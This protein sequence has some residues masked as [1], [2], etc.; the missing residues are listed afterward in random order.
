M[1]TEQLDGII[2]VY[3]RIYIYTYIYTYYAHIVGY[4]TSIFPVVPVECVVW[5]LSIDNYCIQLMCIYPYVYWPWCLWVWPQYTSGKPAKTN[6]KDIFMVAAPARGRAFVYFLL[7]CL[8]C[9]SVRLCFFLFASC[10]GGV[11]WVKWVGEI[12]SLH[13]HAHLLLCHLLFFLLRQKNFSSTS[14][15]SARYVNATLYTSHHVLRSSLALP[16]R[17]IVTLSYIYIYIYIRVTWCNVIRTSRK[18]TKSSC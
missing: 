12:R 8:V 11:G 17:L 6:T 10:W 9:V 1:Q 16:Y 2:Y 13:L 18:S 5:W 15:S 14:T 4:T 3:I 7:P